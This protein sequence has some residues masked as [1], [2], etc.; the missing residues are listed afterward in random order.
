M[1][2]PYKSQMSYVN[3]QILIKTYGDV[4]FKIILVRILL[5]FKV[6]NHHGFFGCN[7]QFFGIT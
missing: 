3:N 4:I 2:L 1:L 6:I 7:Y 5:F